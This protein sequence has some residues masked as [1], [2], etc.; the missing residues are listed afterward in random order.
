M[1]IELI[2]FNTT[3]SNNIIK[4]SYSDILDNTIANLLESLNGSDIQ[5]L[6][7]YNDNR[8]KYSN[9]AKKRGV[10]EI[11]EIDFDKIKENIII[12]N[13][14]ELF[15]SKSPF[16]SIDNELLTSFI[17]N[18]KKYDIDLIIKVPDFGTD[19]LLEVK[20][21]IDSLYIKR[22]EFIIHKK[23]DFDFLYKEMRRYITLKYFLK[24]I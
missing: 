20:N 8:I 23:T 11:K 19:A 7:I 17:E 2:Y 9:I 4:W 15:L 22:D 14:F 12:F 1:K 3:I 13:N 21:I 10:K 18:C 16:V 24:P 6:L 5:P